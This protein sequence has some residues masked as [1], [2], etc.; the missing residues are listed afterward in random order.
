MNSDTI[1]IHPLRLAKEIH[2]VLDDDTIVIGDG[3]NIVSQAAKVINVAKPGHWL[4]PGRFGCLGVGV[5]FAIAA[6]IVHPKS[7]VVVINGDGAFG[8]NGFEF[9]TAVRFNLPMVSVVGND[10]AWGQIRG[11]QMNFYGV[12]RA[13]ASALALTRYDQVVQALGGYG[14]YVDDPRTLRGALERA[15]ASGKPACVNVRIDAEANAAV[16]ANSMAV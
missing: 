11:P 5:P 16:S 13:V 2:D 12:D 1:P 8:L 4:D 9:D 10:A 15:L 14:E 6:K 3:G 7:N